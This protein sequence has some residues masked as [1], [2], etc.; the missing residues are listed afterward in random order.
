MRDT[1][2]DEAEKYLMSALSNPAAGTK[3]HNDV[4]LTVRNLTNGRMVMLAWAST[5]LRHGVPYE[6]MR[7]VTVP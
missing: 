1:S 5:S 4:K 2:D 6:G 7:N 3:L